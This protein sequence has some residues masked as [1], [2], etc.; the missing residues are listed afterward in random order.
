M[1]GLALLLLWSF[2]AF[3]EE[4]AYRGYLF[5]RFAEAAAANML[6]GV[7]AVSILLG[8]GHYYKEP[9]GIL[10]SAVAGLGSGRGRPLVAGR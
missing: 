7:L 6:L 3:G 1:A 10:H 5:G 2:A 9:G 8:Y 4:V